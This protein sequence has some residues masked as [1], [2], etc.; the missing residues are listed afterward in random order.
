MAL[1]RHIALYDLHCATFDLR[2]IV[3]IAIVL[4]VIIVVVVIIIIILIV[5]VIVVLLI[6]LII[7]GGSLDG[8]RLSSSRT[9]ATPTSETPRPGHGWGS[10]LEHRW[11]GGFREYRPASGG[12][13]G[14]RPKDTAGP[15]KTMRQ[16]SQ[17]YNSQ[18]KAPTV[19]PNRK[20]ETR[21]YAD[22]AYDLA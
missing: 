1:S 10:R 16:K 15:Q 22:W 19:R 4:R 3:V 7:V 2:P 17:P 14:A 5:I 8:T 6:I 9:S 20:Q 18:E 12:P 21:N 11:E 13:S